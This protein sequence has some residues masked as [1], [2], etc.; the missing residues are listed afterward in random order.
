MKMIKG[1]CRKHSCPFLVLTIMVLVVEHCGTH[2][3]FGGRA[4]FPPLAPLGPET[5]ANLAQTPSKSTLLLD[6]R[7]IK[8]GNCHFAE[9]NYK[10]DKRKPSH[11]FGYLSSAPCLIFHC[12]VSAA[13]GAA[14]VLYTCAKAAAQNPLP[15]HDMQKQCHIWIHLVFGFDRQPMLQKT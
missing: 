8:V 15:S 12:R 2:C 13:T 5:V 7:L 6:A 11:S 14:L 1:T 9:T 3:L 10:T 4:G